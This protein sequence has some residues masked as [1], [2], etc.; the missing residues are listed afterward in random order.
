MKKSHRIL[1][2]VSLVIAFCGG[3]L[4]LIGLAN[5]LQNDSDQQTS[6]EFS[7]YRLGADE[8]AKGN[9]LD[10]SLQNLRALIKNDPYDGRA[11]YELA[12]A[13]YS[14][15]VEAQDSIV[16]T[17]RT[18]STELKNLQSSTNSR[19]TAGPDDQSPGAAVVEVAQDQKAEV[20]KLVDQA[21]QEYKLAEKHARYR[22]RSQIQLAVLLA[23]RGDY[24][25]A[26]DKLEN[27]VNGGGA[28]RRGLD[29]IEQFSLILQ[30]PTKL[31][32]YSRFS[33][34]LAMERMNRRGHGG[35]PRIKWFPSLSQYDTGTWNYLERLN[36]DLIP[37]RFKLVNFIRKLFE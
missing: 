4:G 12:S 7:E 13:L 20:A 14:R 35:R 31:H 17:K 19:G 29:Q 25:A 5:F 18:E 30:E 21:I 28:T 32:S 2:D 26:L 36:R 6:S 3:F 23:T 34:I 16:E 15:V 1:R 33:L 8:A 9:D 11:Q 24:E 22:L 27:F 10:I 37:Y